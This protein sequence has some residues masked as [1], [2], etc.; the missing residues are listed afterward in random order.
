MTSYVIHEAA[1]IFPLDE[2]NIPDL[3]ADI[4]KNGQKVAVELF[5]GKVLDGRRRIKACEIAGVEPKYR[6]VD[7]EVADPVSHVLSL[8]QHRRH[9]S[10]SQLSMIGARVREIYEKDAKERQKRKPADSVGSHGPQQNNAGRTRDVVGKL[11]GVSGQSIDRATKVLKQGEPE[12]VKAVDDGRVTVRAAVDLID[13]PAEVQKEAASKTPA[14]RK[15]KPKEEPE[16]EQ[17][18]GEIKLIG[19]GVQYG[20]EAVNCL[21]KIPRSDPLR[22]RGFQIVTDWIK[23]N[24]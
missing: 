9:L 21:Q 1:N 7:K 4:K 16:D 2:E 10:P 19:R 20:H 3:A 24:K 17:P 8:N 15:A 18:K 23:Q 12:L 22:M 5:D 13:E 6:D 14:E 11:M